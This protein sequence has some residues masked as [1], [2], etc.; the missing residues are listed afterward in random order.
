M[1]TPIAIKTR[2]SLYSIVVVTFLPY[3]THADIVNTQTWEVS[4]QKNPVEPPEVI[5][6]LSCIF[7]YELSTDACM[8]RGHLISV[9][10]L[11]LRMYRTTYVGLAQ[12]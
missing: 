10:F 6:L 8:T 3:L 11:I 1:A 12:G 9:N 5:R 2:S 7:S 4:P